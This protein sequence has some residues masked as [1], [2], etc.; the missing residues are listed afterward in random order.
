MYMIILCL[1]LSAYAY[2]RLSSRGNIFKKIFQ[3]NI[4]VCEYFIFLIIRECIVLITFIHYVTYTD[5]QKFILNAYFSHN[6]SFYSTYFLN[7]IYFNFKR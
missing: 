3:T 2:L 4:A 5:T 6:Y 1:C 7:Y